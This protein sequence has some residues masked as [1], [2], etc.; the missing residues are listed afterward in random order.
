M[1]QSV[2]I[3]ATRRWLRTLAV[4][5]SLMFLGVACFGVFRYAASDYQTDYMSFWAAGRLT[6]DGDAAAAYDIARH[7]AVQEDAIGRQSQLMPFP[8]PP[9]FLF[10]VTPFSLAPY[11]PAFVLWVAL[12]ALLYWRAARAYGPTP[13]LM[14]QPAVLLT[15]LIGQTAFLTAA[16]LLAGLRRLGDRPFRA[17]LILGLLV[18]KPQLALL[19]PV[20][21]VAGRLWPAIPGALLSGGAALLA[22]GAVFGGASYRGF[23][24]LLPVYAQWMRGNGW[25]WDEFASPYA[26]VRYF[27][28][29]PAAGLAVQLPFAVLAVAVTALAWARDW[30]EKVPV[31]AAATLLVPPYLLTYDSLLLLVPLAW[32][33]GQGRRTGLVVLVWLGCWLPIG[34]FIGLYTGPNTVPPATLLALFGLLVD[35]WA[36][37]RRSTAF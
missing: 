3:G 5:V 23:L 31:L 35:H 34:H 32:W 25:P 6:L 30:R 13:L 29:S 9:P 37:T 11:V 21:V 20:A 33:I 24:D 28:A 27:G 8:Y 19:L 26:F 2:E 12:T 15:Y 22:A 16:I 18:I 14:A 36:T 10:A 7:H 1:H 4:A 17:G